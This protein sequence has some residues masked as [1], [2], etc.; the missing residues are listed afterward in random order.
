MLGES[1]SVG[2]GPECCRGV[3][4]KPVF[5]DLEKNTGVGGEWKQM[6]CDMEE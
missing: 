3:N 6:L 2:K 4:S 1:D 5:E